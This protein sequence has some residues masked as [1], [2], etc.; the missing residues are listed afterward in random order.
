MGAEADTMAGIFAGSSDNIRSAV[1][2]ICEGLSQKRVLFVEVVV[3]RLSFLFA[4]I[5]RV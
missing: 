4:F 1:A 3:A 5:S 2:F